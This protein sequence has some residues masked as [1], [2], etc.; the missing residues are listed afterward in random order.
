MDF[1]NFL[2]VSRGFPSMW[3]FDCGIVFL[4]M[5]RWGIFSLET[6]VMGDQKGGYENSEVVY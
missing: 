5:R 2:G 6:P 3:K 4:A 1:L